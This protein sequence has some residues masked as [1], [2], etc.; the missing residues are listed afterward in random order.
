MNDTLLGSRLTWV[1]SLEAVAFEN[2]PSTI[3]WIDELVTCQFTAVQSIS[4]MNERI[5]ADKA[6]IIWILQSQ[7]LCKCTCGVKLYH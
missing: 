5:T 4:E 1:C 7:D 6:S 3:P 2:A